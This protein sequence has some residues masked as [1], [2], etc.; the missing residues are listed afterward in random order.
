MKLIVQI[1]FLRIM[2]WIKGMRQ[3]ASQPIPQLAKK[4]RS[5]PSVKKPI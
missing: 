4:F 3:Y 1:K 2:F 5:N